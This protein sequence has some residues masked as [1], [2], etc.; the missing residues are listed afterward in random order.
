MK[1]RMSIAKKKRNYRYWLIDFTEPNQPMILI[2]IW[3]CLAMDFF[4]SLTSFTFF[5]HSFTRKHNWLLSPILI[6]FC[7]VW[8]DFFKSNFRNVFL[9]LVQVRS[10]FCYSFYYL[11]FLLSTFCGVCEN[12]NLPDFLLVWKYSKKTII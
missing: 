10:I 9:S 1:Y 4:F 12:K 5:I 7:L 3:H 11:V 6:L 2:I 8:F